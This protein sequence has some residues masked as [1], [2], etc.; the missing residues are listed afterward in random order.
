MKKALRELLD[1]C[2]LIDARL[3]V[4]KD[5]TLEDETGDKIYILASIH[6]ELKQRIS[7]AQGVLSNGNH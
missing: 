6:D 7:K 2:I 5:N 1:L 3:D 4:E